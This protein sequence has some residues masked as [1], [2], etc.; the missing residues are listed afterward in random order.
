[1]SGA[2]QS[3]KQFTGSTNDATGHSHGVRSL[4]IWGAIAT[5]IAVGIVVVL[6]VDAQYKNKTTYSAS[7]KGTLVNS[8]LL[9]LIGSSRTSTLNTQVSQSSNPA[10][11]PVTSATVKVNDHTIPLPASGNGSVHQE[12]T[13]SDGSKVSVDMNVSSTSSSDSS[14]FELNL[15]SAQVSVN[16]SE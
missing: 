12:V 11:A 1:M 9:P 4:L 7:A 14:T 13:S 3:I 10:S 5:L 6:T 8:I 2:I 15:N 16:N